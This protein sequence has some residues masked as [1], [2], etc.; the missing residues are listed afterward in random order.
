MEEM[1]NILEQ[2]LCRE[3]ELIE[4]KY[5]NTQGEMSIQD[6]DKLDKLYH[7][8]KSKATYDAMKEYGYENNM[9]RHTASGRY[10]NRDGGSSY[11]SGY[12]QGYSEAMNQMNAG[13]SGHFPMYSSGFRY[14]RW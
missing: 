12:S 13:N 11:E 8:L 10:T 5:Q 7:T 6:V 4:Q 14:P 2:K 9:S 1:H 3:I